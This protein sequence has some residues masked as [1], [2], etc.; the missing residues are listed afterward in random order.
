MVGIFLR[1]LFFNCMK[2]TPTIWVKLLTVA[3]SLIVATGC[4]DEI[5]P[6]TE[7]GTD[8][9]VSSDPIATSIITVAIKDGSA[10]NII[11]ESSCTTVIFPISGELNDEIRTFNALEEVEALGMAALEIDWVFPLEVVL[12][13]HTE[14]T[15]TTEDELEAIQDNC[16]EG[17]NDLDNECIDFVYPLIVQV[18]D[19]RTEQADTRTI[20]NDRETYT[21]FTSTDLIITIE[22]PIDM[23]DAD[24]SSIQMFSNDALAQTIADAT[25]TCDENDIVEFE[26]VFE[27]ELRMIFTS[28]D[29]RVSFYEEEGDEN[30]LLFSGYTIQFN[31]DYTL[32]SQ[33]VEVVVGDWDLDLDEGEE[34]VSIEFDTDTEPLVLLNEYWLILDHDQTQI[35]LEYRDHE[36]IIK[37]LQLTA[38]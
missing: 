26:E 19:T 6:E 10:D 23:V 34:A 31:E 16:I 35:D 8:G 21:T 37:R 33:G 20:T 32:R 5:E 7:I 2:N 30:T 15:L 17:G 13:D 28:S 36:D 4:Q 3:I 9:I 14:V 12:S 22:Y 38:N 1:F 27:E 24:G 25:N 29:W 11:D 18:F